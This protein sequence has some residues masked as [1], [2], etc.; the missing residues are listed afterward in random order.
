MSRVQSLR[1]MLAARP[2]DARLRFGLALEYLREGAL[3]EAVAELRT[4]LAAASDEGN[5]W[6][7][8]GAA[9][10]ELGRAAE[11]REAYEAGILAAERHGHPTMAEEFRQAL[12]ELED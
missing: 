4:Y 9:L 3:E 6:G 12:E 11:A 2:A 8:L 5:A 10:A 1:A 7:R